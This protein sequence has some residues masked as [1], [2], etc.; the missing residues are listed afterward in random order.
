MSSRGWEHVCST[1]ILI[2][3]RARALG[4]EDTFPKGHCA[5]EGASGTAPD[6]LAAYS[7]GLLN[8][9]AS[10]FLPSNCPRS[11]CLSPLISLF[12]LGRKRRKNKQTKTPLPSAASSWDTTRMNTPNMRGPP[13]HIRSLCQRL[14][15]DPTGRA[16]IQKDGPQGST[17]PPHC[18]SHRGWL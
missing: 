8:H 17:V 11:Q 2:E 16:T 3:P 1:V 10:S 6:S 14:H 18:M 13:F 9:T 7:R 4:T 15:W 5:F 12:F